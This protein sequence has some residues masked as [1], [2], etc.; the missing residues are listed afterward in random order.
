MGGTGSIAV[1][2]HLD[3]LDINN[4]LPFKAKLIDGHDL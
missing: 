2:E 1:G 4:A 3:H